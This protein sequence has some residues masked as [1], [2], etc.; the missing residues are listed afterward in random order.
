VVRIRSHLVPPVTRQQP[1]VV[2]I[3]IPVLV[4]GLQLPLD[5]MLAAVVLAVG[6]APP[7]D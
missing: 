5:W 4:M 6:A 7:L 2:R 1:V 3:R